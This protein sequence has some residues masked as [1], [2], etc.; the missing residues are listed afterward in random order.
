MERRRT[1]SQLIFGGCILAV[2]VTALVLP[3]ADDGLR[4]VT[5]E[6]IAAEVIGDEEAA[7]CIFDGLKERDIDPDVLDLL[8]NVDA[9][10]TVVDPAVVD[11][12]SDVIAGCGALTLTGPGA[13]G[14]STPIDPELETASGPGT[15]QV[16]IVETT[17]P[18]PVVEIA[19]DGAAAV[20]WLPSTET[21]RVDP[22]LPEAASNRSP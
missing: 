17:I 2:L 14:A 8:L 16:A 18:T 1:R 11:G 20:V 5:R 12:V 10:E 9:D 19:S 21:V 13:P 22:E 15:A 6:R 7:G 3:S 4:P